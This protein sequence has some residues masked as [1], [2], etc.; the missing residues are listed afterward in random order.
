MPKDPEFFAS[1]PPRLAALPEASRAEALLHIDYLGEKAG[2]SRDHLLAGNP[3]DVHDQVLR[4]ARHNIEAVLSREASPRDMSVAQLIELGERTLEGWCSREKA[5]AIAEFVTSERPDLCVE[6]G[7]Y[8]GRSLVPA[9][10]ALRHNGS[11]VIY[12]VET[13]R[14]DVA[15]EHATTEENDAWW[16]RL[17]FHTIK[18]NFYRFIAEHG[19][20]S[21][22]RIIEAPSAEAAGLFSTIDY[23]HI[24]GAHSI[25]NAAEDVVLYA[26]KV[27]PNGIIIMDDANWATTAPALAI[28]DSLGTRIREFHNESGK[29]ACIAYRKRN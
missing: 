29:V 9:A 24:D 14:P 28:L 16:Q 22:V 11:G 4:D 8:G 12:G 19:L 15:A 27:R 7:V 20:A 17:D 25:Y 23:L 2:V 13:W 21:T 18:T 6:I 1:L 26:K 5:E 10:A 3:F